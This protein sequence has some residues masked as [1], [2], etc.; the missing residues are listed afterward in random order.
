MRHITILIAVLSIT[1]SANAAV[2]I[3]YNGI[4]NPLETPVLDPLQT[5]N[6]GIVSNSVLDGPFWFVLGIP[7]GQPG[8]LTREN[9][10]PQDPHILIAPPEEPPLYSGFSSWIEFSYEGLD[11]VPA[12]LLINDI[13]F[14]CTGKGNVDMLLVGTLY[15]DHWLIFDKQMIEQTPEPATIAMLGLGAMLLKRRR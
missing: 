2:S 10:E 8:L 7:Q 9:I 12:G 11:P 5:A 1:V 15:F 14:H 4:T 6:I 13:T 3:V